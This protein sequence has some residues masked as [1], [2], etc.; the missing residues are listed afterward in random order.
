VVCLTYVLELL[1][2]GLRYWVAGLHT[3]VDDVR[4][5]VADSDDSNDLVVVAN[6]LWWVWVAWCGKGIGYQRTNDT[7]VTVP[8]DRQGGDRTQHN[9]M[10]IWKKVTGI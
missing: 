6:D 2:A 8:C 7:S 1:E 9:V 5:Q 10:M 4:T 3:A